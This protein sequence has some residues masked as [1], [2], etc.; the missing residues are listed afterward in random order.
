MA[1]DSAPVSIPASEGDPAT[2]RIRRTWRLLA[3]SFAVLALAEVIAVAARPGLP[4][5]LVVLALTGVAGIAAVLHQRAAAAAEAGRR[6]EAEHVTRILRGLGRSA[7]PDAIVE[8]IVQELAIG[9]GADHVAVVRL[10]PEGILEATLVSARA[11]VPNATTLLAL[12]DLDPGPVETGQRVPVGIP[13]DTGST[14]ATAPA[15]VPGAG[16]IAM[17]E[18]ATTGAVIDPGAPAGPAALVAASSDSTS[19]LSS[20]AWSTIS[21]AA[22]SP[23]PGPTRS[24]AA[25]ADHLEAKVAECFGLQNTIGAPLWTGKVVGVIVL[26]R[27]TAEPWPAA[28][29]RILEGAAVEASG[30]L[31]RVES[32]RAA[33]VSASTDALTGLPNRR[34]FDEFCGLLARRRRADDA[35]GILMVDIDHFKRINDSHGH[36]VG[37]VVLR[38]V[39]GAIAG[40]VRDVDVPARVGGEEFAVI[41]RNP[42]EHVAVEVGERVRAAVGALDLQ[43]TGVSRVRVSVGVAVQDQPDEPIA[44]IVAD[45]DRALYRAKRLGRD[46]VVTA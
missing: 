7:S 35:V 16:A 13:I 31:G 43:G 8:A 46:R 15:G 36:E 45:A 30:A 23:S 19:V 11:N 41:L 28:S 20:A 39:A 40:A 26:S 17:V 32:H 42:T 4:V 1:A 33:Q 2:R 18:E 3:A 22:S 34:Y 37:D 21:S 6:S 9:T 24:A 25:I 38:A 44:T 5:D 12:S 29:R 14:P 27:R 10:K